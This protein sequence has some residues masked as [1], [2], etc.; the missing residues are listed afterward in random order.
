MGTTTSW[1]HGEKPSQGTMHLSV[2]SAY[3]IRQEGTDGPDWTQHPGSEVHVDSAAATEDMPR[4]E[5][6][7]N[8]SVWTKVDGLD[9]KTFI[10]GSLGC[11]GYVDLSNIQL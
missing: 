7:H 4:D 8:T 5:K 10:T 9:L 6:D 2:I 11:T 3:S 1:R